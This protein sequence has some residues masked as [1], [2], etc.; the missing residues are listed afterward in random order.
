[1]IVD[2]KNKVFNGHEVTKQEALSLLSVPLAEL[3]ECANEIRKHFCGN[4]FDICTIINGKCGNCSENCKYCA[5]SISFSTDI[6]SHALLDSTTI[7]NDAK[8]NESKGIMHYAVVTSGRKL[9]AKDLDNLCRTYKKISAN[10]NISLCASN[11]LLSYDD[12]IKL[13]KAGLKRYHNNLETSR[14]FFPMICTTH[15]YDDK[16][17]TIKTAQ[18]AG[19]EVCSGGIIGLGESFEDRIDMALDL[20]TLKIKSIP[21]NILNAIKGTAL[22]NNP[23]LSTEEILRTIAIFRFIIPNA[24]IRL[25]G[26]R[27][28]LKDKGESAFLS[29]ANAAISGDMLTIA[30][31]T[32]DDDFRL[33]SKLGYTTKKCSEK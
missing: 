32:I 10:C 23:V 6:N 2:L 18:N 3:C 28:L 15:T 19:L 21:I 7:L 16:L 30:G 8:Y 4:N 1:M 25:A 13:K 26:G 17:L 5:Q 14:R 22:E 11:G 29:G 9:P 12:F 24:F 20:R 27:N 31:I 33:I